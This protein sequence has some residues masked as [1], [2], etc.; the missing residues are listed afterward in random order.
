MSSISRKQNDETVEDSG[1]VMLVEKPIDNGVESVEN[2]KKAINDDIS[3]E[4]REGQRTDSDRTE[5]KRTCEKQGAGGRIREGNKNGRVSEKR[6]DGQ[7]SGTRSK[8]TYYDHKQRYG[9]G[10]KGEGEEVE[11]KREH[12]ENGRY[13]GRGNGRQDRS[14]W[15][16][17]RENGH[18][19]RQHRDQRRTSDGAREGR[20]RETRGQRSN[21][22]RHGDGGGGGGVRTYCKSNAYS[23]KDQSVPRRQW[24]K[25]HREDAMP[26]GPGA[27][28]RLKTRDTDTQDSHDPNHKT[29]NGEATTQE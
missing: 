28:V 29:E 1:S 15:K 18:S 16:E 20:Q 22:A 8:R 10:R 13:G 4:M 21:R 27:G 14:V 9:Q 3:G 2:E 11:R 12:R 7:T 5:S 19:H 24:E 17:G 6:S 26:P 25:K 23:A